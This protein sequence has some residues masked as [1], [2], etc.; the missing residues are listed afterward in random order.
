MVDFFSKR[1]WQKAWPVCLGY[2]PLGL[3]CGMFAQK[4]GLGILEVI[5][6]CVIVYAGSAQFIGMAMMMQSASVLSIVLTI[7]IVNL[8]HFL[9]S[10]TLLKYLKDRSPAFLAFYAYEITDESFAVNFSAFEQGDWKPEDALKVNIISHATW[11]L[12]NVLGFLGSELISVDTN[13]VGYA[14]TAMFIGLWSFYLGERKMLIAGL[15]S[16][17]L[18]MFLSLFVG[19]KMHVV[20]AA[21]A[22]A[23]AG[24]FYEYR[25]NKRVKYE[26]D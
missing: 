1:I 26:F 6:L 17:F 15:L 11:V 21:V 13:L 16:G 14:L 8:R 23:S 20:L 7:F 25:V 4:T 22:V 12:S 19:Y 10:S 9:F 18:A 3:A 24:C 5:G 2:L